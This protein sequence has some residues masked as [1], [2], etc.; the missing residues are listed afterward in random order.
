MKAGLLDSCSL[1]I[2]YLSGGKVS[3]N[4]SSSLGGKFVFPTKITNSQQA[5]QYL[6]AK[7]IVRSELIASTVVEFS[8]SRIMVDGEN[9]RIDKDEE[10]N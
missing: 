2:E 4:R 1:D 9:Y 10:G 8:G 6:Q 7:I 3:L 5:V